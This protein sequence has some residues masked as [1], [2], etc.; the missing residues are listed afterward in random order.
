MKKINF[1]KIFLTISVVLQI[2]SANIAQP[3]QINDATLK[4]APFMEAADEISLLTHS[5]CSAD[6]ADSACAV[7]S[8]NIYE[9]YIKQ[10]FGVNWKDIE[11]YFDS[12]ATRLSPKK[13]AEIYSKLTELKQNQKNALLYVTM[14]DK[15]LLPSFLGLLIDSGADVNLANQSIPFIWR[16]IDNKRHDLVKTLVEKGVDVNIFMND[17]LNLTTPLHYSLENDDLELAQIV[18]SSDN[19]DINKLDGNGQPPIVTAINA[20]N[21][22]S[23]EM[24]LSTG[25]VNLRLADPIVGDPLV[26]ATWTGFSDPQIVSL[27]LKNGIS[28]AQAQNAYEN[29]LRLARDG[30]IDLSEGNTKAILNLLLSFITT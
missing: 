23:V 12:R 17:V 28:I 3:R 24:L 15:R 29:M 1:L 20:D 6:S 27:L 18:L 8:R 9:D 11:K 22:C 2:K 7:R 5:D 16:A 10:N 13:S 14:Q 25:R 19:I 26:A 4:L 30:Q 21:P